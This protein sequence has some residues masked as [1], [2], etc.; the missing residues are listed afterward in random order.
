MALN[1]F[2]RKHLDDFLAAIRPVEKAYQHDSFGYVALKSL[3]GFVVVQGALY[4]NPIPRTYPPWRFET[5]NILASHRPLFEFQRTREELIDQ[6]CTGS[7]TTPDG[8]LLFPGNDRSDHGAQFYPIHPR[9]SLVQSRVSVLS[10][11]GASRRNFDDATLDWELR[12]A[13]RPFESLLD[14]MNEYQVGVPHGSTNTIEV[15]AQSVARIHGNSRVDG[16]QAIIDVRLAKGLSRDLVSVGFRV[17]AQGAVIRRS[18][19]RKEGFT[20][21]EDDTCQR[22]IGQIPVPRA[23]VVQCTAVYAGTAQHYYQFGD[24]KTFQNS[25]RAAY[26]TFDAK[27]EALDE[28]L[29]QTGKRGKDARLFES[30]ISWIF[31]MLGFSPANL[32]GTPRTEDAP[33]LVFCTPKGHFAVI[34]C[35]AGLLKTDHKLPKLHSRAQALRQSLDASNA[36]HLHVLARLIHRSYAGERRM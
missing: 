25:R 18:S 11:Y 36:A 12:G 21:D 5:E 4:L 1:D 7:F 27:L 22:G 33:D 10:L 20:W 23:A 24:P 9:G 17:T 15:L 30:A 3:E 28:T 26:E 13:H 29:A 6:I 16:E 34:E 14:L 32:G 19:L 31:W 35:T 8:P 2:T